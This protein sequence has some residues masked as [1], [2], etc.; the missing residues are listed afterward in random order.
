MRDSFKAKDVNPEISM[1]E[2]S[3]WSESTS[4][5]KV[6]I[7]AFGSM[8]EHPGAELEAATVHRIEVVTPFSVEFARSS[9][10]R[11]GAPTLVP[12]SEGGAHIPGSVLILD[13]SV[14]VADARAMLYRRETGRLA[15]IKVG[16]RLGWIAQLP[17]YENLNICLYAALE[18]NIPPPLTAEKLAE[19]ALRSALGP[20]GTK[21]R[22]GIS[23]LEQ[24]KR[25]GIETPLMRPY[26]EAVLVRLEAASLDEAWERV[27][28]GSASA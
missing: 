24:Q 8:V 16:S 18:A 1:T 26:E 22:D 28:S 7:L 4:S 19:L 25:R 20:S 14:A 2:R 6:G 5:T 17:D 3:G 23:Y 21:R 27:R 11:D 13:S 9:R 10:T 12:V 15:D